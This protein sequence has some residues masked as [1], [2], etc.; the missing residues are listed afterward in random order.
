MKN[1]LTLDG[2]LAELTAHKES[3]VPGDIRIFLTGRSTGYA[4]QAEGTGKLAVA[5]PDHESGRG[6]CKIVSNRGVE[7]LTIL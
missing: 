6:M 2:L 1:K 7:V 3:G 5:K 4:T